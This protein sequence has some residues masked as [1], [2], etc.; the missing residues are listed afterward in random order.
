MRHTLCALLAAALLASGCGDDSPNGPTGSQTQQIVNSTFIVAAGQYQ[1]HR[2]A[3]DLTQM[4]NVAVDGQ[5]STQGNSGDIDVALLSEGN[6]ENWK[7]GRE[8]TLT[9]YASGRT[10][11]GS[12]G[13]RI[14]ESGVYYLIFSNSFGD[15]GDKTV[16][17]DVRLT[18]DGE[19]VLEE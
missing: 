16:T 6:F 3:V 5:F 9:L 15:T 18:F 19:E 2:F 13:V 7:A 17:A 1:E 12:L 4:S 8:I 10:G 11:S 14:T